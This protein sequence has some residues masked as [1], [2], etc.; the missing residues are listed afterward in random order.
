MN[1]ITYSI[2][3]NPNTKDEHI[4]ELKSIIDN[5]LNTGSVLYRKRKHRL[6]NR[7]DYNKA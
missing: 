1:F 4:L 3:S 5:W 2:T 7:N 6:A